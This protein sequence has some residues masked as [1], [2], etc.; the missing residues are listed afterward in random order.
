MDAIAKMMY[1]VESRRREEK[2][3]KYRTRSRCVKMAMEI[4][5]NTPNCIWKMEAR[6]QGIETETWK[7][8]AKYFVQVMQMREK[9]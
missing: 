4:S 9:R 8:A 7:R 2:R 6:V 3:W 1:G 5:R